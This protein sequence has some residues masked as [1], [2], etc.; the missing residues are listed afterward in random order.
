MTEE[1]FY[2][3][4]LKYLKQAERQLLAAIAE[5]PYPAESG[6]PDSLHPIQYCISRIKS[7]ESMEAKLK[8]RG[9]PV[10]AKTALNEV[11]DALGVRIIC[12]FMDDVYK[13]ADWLLKRP[14]IEAVAKK[15]YIAYPK[16]NGYRSYHLIV[17]I[18][19]GP[20]KGVTAEIQ[21]RTI[22]LDFWASLEHQLKY[23]HEVADEALVKEE[24]KRC[25]DEIVS[26]DLS[27]QTIRDCLKNNFQESESVV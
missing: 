22:A 6:V 16:P 8:K 2:G 14:E 3:E 4:E 17:K 23:K 21:M 19:D 7:P 12:S 20:G 25:A 18:L 24:L 1:A 26:V 11:N 27:M 15:D 9:L 5:Y 13:I 10:N